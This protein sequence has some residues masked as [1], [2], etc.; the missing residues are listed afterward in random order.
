MAAENFNFIALSINDQIAT[1]TLSRPPVNALSKAMV[2]ELA[3]VAAQLSRN[4]DVHVVV[5]RSD[6]KHFCAGADLKERARIPENEIA[7]VVGDLRAT[8]QAIASL[9]QPVIASVNGSALG[10]GAEL[11]LACDFRFMAPDT[12][13]GMTEVS[14]GIIPGAGGTVRLPRLVGPSVAKD[15]IFSARIIDGVSCQRLGLADRMVPGPELDESVRGYAEQLVVQAPLAL[16]AAKRAIN[17]G[18]DLSIENAL[19]IEG[20]AYGTIIATEDRIEGLKAYL[21]KHRPVWRGR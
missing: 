13:F 12:R 1:V 10:G 21:S 6:Q 18:M 2:G 17:G 4:D 19:E 3:A 20:E 14:L 11:A 8:F 5:L 9:P 16:R 7:S 15:L